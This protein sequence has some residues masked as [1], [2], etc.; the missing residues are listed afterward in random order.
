MISQI[1][2]FVGVNLNEA[3]LNHIRELCS[4]EF[5]AKNEN[6]FRPTN[7]L[8]NYRNTIKE[9]KDEWEPNQSI[10]RKDG[11]QIGQGRKNIGP[12]LRGV[13]DKFWLETMEKSFGYQSYEALYQA[14]TRFQ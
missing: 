12:K 14:N 4:F 2:S 10:V 8:E 3:E 6:K 11:G 13:L 1:S 5:M 7:V 9:S